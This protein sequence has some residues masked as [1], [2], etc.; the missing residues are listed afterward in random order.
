V[1]VTA[2][3]GCDRLAPPLPSSETVARAVG[4]ADEA[5]LVGWPPKD[6][7]CPIEPG[8]APVTATAIT[9]TATTPTE[10]NAIADLRPSQVPRP[11]RCRAARGGQRSARARRCSA[12]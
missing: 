2:G 10:V 9:I 6:I 5:A 3:L 4:A 7:I 12:G 8:I 11:R 1:P